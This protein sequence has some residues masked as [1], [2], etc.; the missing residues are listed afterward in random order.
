[1][2]FAGI[3]NVAE[4]SFVTD[5]L[6]KA[7]SAFALVIGLWGL[8]FAVGSLAGSCGGSP[9]RLWAAY[10]LGLT[11]TGAGMLAAGVAPSFALVL[12]AFVLFGAGN[13][14]AVVHE[15]LLVAELTHE[16][17]RGRA[18][19]TLEMA[20]SWSL[21]VAFTLGALAVDLV[22]AREA[23]ILAGVGT[24]VVT[25]FVIAARGRAPVPRSAP[26]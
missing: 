25:S 17:I 5:D 3:S 19:G 13:G 15:R 26:L 9:G 2:L 4:P 11:G 16:R 24:L 10:L 20:A 18:Y 1:M 23:M 14:L 6:G 8:G 22:G 7:S 12:P 21:A